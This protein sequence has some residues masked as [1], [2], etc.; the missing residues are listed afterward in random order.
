MSTQQAP[1]PSS[2]EVADAR[3][4]INDGIASSPE[5]F[6]YEGSI[7]FEFV[8]ECGASSCDEVVQLTVPQY[9]VR[10]LGAVVA[11]PAL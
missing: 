8:C 3:R 1:A 7:L 5:R 6:D 4:L 10:R 9:G 2:A 11:H